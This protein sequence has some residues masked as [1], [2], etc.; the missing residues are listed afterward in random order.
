MEKTNRLYNTGLLSITAATRHI[1][2]RQLQ[3]LSNTFPIKSLNPYGI[4]YLIGN[5]SWENFIYGKLLLVILYEGLFLNKKKK[6]NISAFLL[7]EWN[8]T[9][10]Q[11]WMGL[12]F[13]SWVTRIKVEPCSFLKNWVSQYKNIHRHLILI[14]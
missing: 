9:N 4:F 11:R 6:L 10:E 5:S 14:F 7:N 1:L 8:K 2:Q 3:T 12:L 13:M